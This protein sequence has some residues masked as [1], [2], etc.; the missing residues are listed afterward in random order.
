M[1]LLYLQSFFCADY[2]LFMTVYFSNVPYITISG[3][4][5]LFQTFLVN[6]EIYIYYITEQNVIHLDIFISTVISDTFWLFLT[7]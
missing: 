7:G 3:F 2:F 4:L 1:G 5:N 6:K